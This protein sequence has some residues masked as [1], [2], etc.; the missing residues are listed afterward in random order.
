M[1]SDK[2]PVMKTAFEKAADIVAAKKQGQL[3]LDTVSC[4]V[5]FI[6]EMLEE[7]SYEVSERKHER[8][9]SRRETERLSEENRFLRARLDQIKRYAELEHRWFAPSEEGS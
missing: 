7:M 1:N 8:S 3:T 2:E 4:A 6:G 9:A 5:D